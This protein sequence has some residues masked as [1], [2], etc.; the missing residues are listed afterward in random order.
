M[1]HLPFF[2]MLTEG[3]Y[4]TI[5]AKLVSGHL[6]RSSASQEFLDEARL[7][8]L[9]AGAK[10][11]PNDHRPTRFH[12]AGW[13]SS[14]WK[15]QHLAITLEPCVSYNDHTDAASPEFFRRFGWDSLPN[16]LAVTALV[17]SEG[18][19][20][21]TH[22]TS[23][24]YKKGGLHFS[25]GGFISIEKEPG[26]DPVAALQRELLEE[27][28]IVHNEI[29]KLV[30]L[31]IAWDPWQNKPDVLFRVKTSVPISVINTRKTDGENENYWMPILPDYA[32][33]LIASACHSVVPMGLA[34][35]LFSGRAHFGR[36]WFEQWIT[37]LARHGDDYDRA[38]TRAALERSDIARIPLLLAS[39]CT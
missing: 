16:A 6:K 7:K 38:E 39:L 1:L 37:R 36:K 20:L 28:G 35:L 14:R 23:A 18:K 8:R 10:E 34:A 27:V 32:N 11:W 12:F 2:H 30:C 9:A 24:D 21:I 22:R 33:H 25:M 29:E 4:R 19:M 26:G 17:E 15:P 13:T 5:S 31:G 3:P